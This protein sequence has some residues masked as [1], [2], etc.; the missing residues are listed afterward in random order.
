[1]NR[2]HIAMVLWLNPA[3]GVLFNKL[4][5]YGPQASY[6]T[7][8]AITVRTPILRRTPTQTGQAD[9]VAV[10]RS[11]KRPWT[12]STG[13]QFG[14]FVIVPNFNPSEGEKC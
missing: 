6:V 12:K 10:C 1:M 11:L 9:C 13:T 8:P 5:N 7:T 3:S 4:N 14:I 2:R